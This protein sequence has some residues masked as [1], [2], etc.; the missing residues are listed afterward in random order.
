MLITRPNHDIATN[1][2]YYWSVILINLAK[3]R[4]MLVSDLAKERANPLEFTS[5]VTKT[6]PKL[7]VFN[8][9]GD[10]SADTGQNNETLVQVDKNHYLLKGSVVY[11]RSCKSAHKLGPK[12]VIVG[13]S[14]YIGYDED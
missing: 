5:V 10:D 11:A 6:K 7:I 8:G 12:A 1:Y 13:Y 3:K 2:L 9:H 14:A 4:G